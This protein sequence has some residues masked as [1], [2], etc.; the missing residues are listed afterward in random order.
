MLSAEETVI[1]LLLGAVLGGAIGFERQTHGRPAGFRT[2]ML[3]SVASVLLMIV[4]EHYYHL[5]LIDPSYVRIDPAR[6]AA[7]AIT[8]V[9]FLGA[10]VIIKHGANVQGLT[11][12]AC[13]WAV[14]AIGLAVGGGLYL[15]AIV[16]TAITI[17]SL[18]L[19]RMVEARMSRLAFKSLTVVA[20]DGL[21][22]DEIL[23]ILK[24]HNASVKN[25]DYEVDVESGEVTYGLM[26]AFRKSSAVKGIVDVLAS[27]ESVKR[28]K[29]KG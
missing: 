3:V 19:L 23:S 1:R 26:V 4:S 15:A 14:A 12:A 6:I 16:A 18:I 13:I 7:G 5:T 9:G 25:V 21:G 11:T 2:Q 27:L 29:F 10:G 20:G 17:S 24:D 8:G 28:V 22:E